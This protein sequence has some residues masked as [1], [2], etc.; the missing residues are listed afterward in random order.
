MTTAMQVSRNRVQQLDELGLF[1]CNELPWRCNNPRC[2]D[3]STACADIVNASGAGVSSCSTSFTLASWCFHAARPDWFSKLY[4]YNLPGTFISYEAAHHVPCLGFRGSNWG[5]NAD[6]VGDGHVEY[7]P[8]EGSLSWGAHSHATGVGYDSDGIDTH[9]L[10]YFAVPPHFLPWM[11][12]APPIDWEALHLLIE[13]RDRVSLPRKV[14]DKGKRITGGLQHGDRGPDVYLTNQLLH[15]K[16][17]MVAEPGDA[18]GLR[19]WF[20]A[21]GYKKR[22]GWPKK[23]TSGKR[24]GKAFAYSILR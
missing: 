9:H 11:I 22:N 6:S 19:T 14:D 5:M 12:P 2:R 15:D 16:G 24:V 8:G 13:W 4:G 18:Y 10:S 21:A 20:A 3:C 17:Y 7:I 1:Y 23:L